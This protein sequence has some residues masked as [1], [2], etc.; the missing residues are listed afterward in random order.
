M[1]EDTPH[2]LFVGERI[3]ARSLIAERVF[4]AKTHGAA[5]ARSAVVAGEG[6]HPLSLQVLREISIDADDHRPDAI[7]DLSMFT[8]DLVVT[9]GPLGRERVAVKPVVPAGNGSPPEDPAATIVGLLAPLHM[10]WDIADPTA[11]SLAR[12]TVGQFREIRDQ[13]ATRIDSLIRDGMLEALRE[14]RKRSAQ[15]IDRSSLGLVAMDAEARF[16]L[17]NSE[18]ERLTGLSRADVIGHS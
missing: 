2:V 11:G 10:H 5:L 17:F 18:A 13:I 8:F 4:S 6:P 1:I 16:F 14:R 12:G 15:R 3:A 9:F 7:D